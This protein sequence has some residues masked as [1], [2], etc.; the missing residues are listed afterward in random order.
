MK[1]CYIHTVEFYSA[2]NKSENMKSVGKWVALENL[3]KEVT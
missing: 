3:L 1:I 2:V